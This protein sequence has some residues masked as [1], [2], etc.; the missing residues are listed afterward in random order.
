[1]H[2]EKPCDKTVVC[3]LKE[4]Y[5]ELPQKA[6][7]LPGNL[8]IHESTYTVLLYTH[9]IDSEMFTACWGCFALFANGASWPTNCKRVSYLTL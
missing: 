8:F 5:R 6:I 4:L 9:T 3:S 1:M 7:F 2:S